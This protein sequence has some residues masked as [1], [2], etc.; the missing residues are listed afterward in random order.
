MSRLEELEAFVAV[1]EAESFTAAADRLS[2]DKSAVSRRVSALESRLTVQLLHR[3]TRRLSLTDAGRGFY[4]HAA[5]ILADLEEAESGVMRAEGELSGLL[6]I[7]L[8]LSF[9]V[10]HMHEP[11]AAFSAQH[12]RVRFQLDLNDR[13]VDLIQ[14]GVDLALRIGRLRDANLIAR[15]L[16][17]VRSVLCASPDYLEQHGEPAGF[18]DLANHRCLVYS[19]LA[20][21][22]RWVGTDAAGQRVE[23]RVKGHLQS[24]SGDFLTEA[25]VEGMGIINQPEFLVC[26][27]IRGGHL[28][29][30]LPDI[31]L[32]TTPAHAIYPPTRHL[33]YRVRA[34]IDFLAD[35]F[36]E[37]LPWS[38]VSSESN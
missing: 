25:A 19:N 11:I 12:P 18:D 28:V 27:S 1:V 8:P 32:P 31:A 33:S 6:R 14:E 38:L 24:S 5:R 17:D 9:G 22:E 23:V 4:A 37:P 30:L 26:D 13:R 35:R 2:A 7:A 16:F 10:Q 36:R 29:R 3:S 15:K 21:P 20:D 34:F